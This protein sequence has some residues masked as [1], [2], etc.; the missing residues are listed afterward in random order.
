MTAVNGDNGIYTRPSDEREFVCG[1]GA[2]SV[3]IIA[4]FPLNKLIFRQQLTG[5]PASTALQQLRHEGVGLLYRGV[6]PPL[7]QKTTSLSI[8]FGM[9]DQ[10]NRILIRRYPAVPS[11][12]R[13]AVSAVLAGCMEATL[14]P[15]ERIQT[16]LQDHGYHQHYRNMAHAMREL[17]LKHGVREYYRGLTA[18]L[19]RN[20]PSNAVFFLLRGEVK[21]RLP[22]ARV[23]GAEVARDF[24]SGGIL[25]AAISTMFFPVNVA[26]TRMQRRVGGN[27]ESF[28][29]A[30]TAVY[31]ERNRSVSAMFR[32]AH[33]NCVRSLLSW[34]IINAT[35]ELLK[36]V[37]YNNESHVN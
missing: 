9:Y 8:M 4:T 32:G 3:N 30:L 7:L 27:F 16:L 1:W 28:F 6:L 29:G 19:V 14:V 24:V 17:G 26:K 5:I 2:A 36:T 15:F 34:G 20:G 37:F 35:Y 18:I 12:L 11:R 10:F 22:T 23:R 21:Q 33:I 25:G 13:R 31:H